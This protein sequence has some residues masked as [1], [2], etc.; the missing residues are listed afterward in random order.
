MTE[1]WNLQCDD[2]R[3]ANDLTTFLIFC[4]DEVS[5]PDYFRCFET[6]T[7]K[8]NPIKGQKSG[9]R[10]VLKAINYCIKEGVM[11]YQEAVHS[12]SPKPNHEKSPCTL[13]HHLVQELMRLGG[14]TLTPIK[15]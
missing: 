1:P 4:E 8:V 14:K 5:E 12:K 7:I 15:N 11:K 6:N 2:E 3:E 9:F 10:H 13:V